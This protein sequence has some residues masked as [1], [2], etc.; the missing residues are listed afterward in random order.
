MTAP[1]KL[2]SITPLRTPAS[3]EDAERALLGAMLLSRT[4][5]DDALVGGLE[6]DD[7][8]SPA[9][10][11]IYQAI[12]RLAGAGESVDPVT[13][14]DELTKAGVLDMAGGVAGL[15]E[16]QS[17]TP[18]T[19]N[20]SSYLRI[21][22][23][24]ARAR[25]LAAGGA[26]I[27]ELAHNQTVD[28]NEALVEAAR[29]IG[30]VQ[31]SH[32]DRTRM[33]DGVTW[34]Q[35]VD[36]SGRALW[37][38]PDRPAWVRGES[39]MITG[40]PGIGKTTLAHQLVCR[41]LGICDDPLLGMPV[42]P[43]DRNLL[44]LSMDRPDQ[45]AAS[46]R[47]MVNPTD[48]AT[49]AGLRRLRVLRG[50]PPKDLARHPDMLAALA[51]EAD[52][53]IVLVDSLKDA[54]I[55][56]T[57]DE[58]GAGWNRAAQGLLASGC[59][60]IVLHHQRKGAGGTKPKSLED[61]YGSTW[62]AAGAGSVLLLWGEPGGPHVQLTH[63][64]QPAEPVG[65]LRLVHDHLAGTTSL[66]ADGGGT[67]SGPDA[68]RALQ[69]APRG[70]DAH[71]L[72]ARSAG[73]GELTDAQLKRARRQLGELE[74]SGKAHRQSGGRGGGSGGAAPD[75]WFAIVDRGEEP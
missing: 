12:R 62:I 46:L 5:I 52:A 71:E 64:K 56:L 57:D 59:E 74:K 41:L 10:G 45:A 66:A 65:P 23:D 58:V 38:T 1:A 13:V 37:G 61:L 8:Y 34:L 69:D 42:V 75:R 48:E 49:A 28:V 40:P 3:N 51:R 39:L 26:E 18:S 7:F 11:H 63:L 53:G 50:P 21:I 32:A 15:I 4:A 2:S 55:G 70:L 47:R 14:A 33:V 25:R 17:D 60:L 29:L 19:R 73:G 31:G 67:S 68:L 36:S 6:V 16:L 43:T 9:R 44:A 20:A 72:A 30:A 22:R 54:A 24:T 27:I 35:G